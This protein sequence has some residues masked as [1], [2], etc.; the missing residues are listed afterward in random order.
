L[1]R[2]YPNRG[3]GRGG[4]GVGCGNCIWYIPLVSQIN[5]TTLIYSHI[6]ISVKNWMTI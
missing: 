6:M 4:N 3:R 5:A 2:S 1:T